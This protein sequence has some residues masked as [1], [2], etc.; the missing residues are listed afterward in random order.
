M[1]MKNS[2]SGRMHVYDLALTLFQV[3]PGNH[4]QKP[5][6]DSLDL[7]NVPNLNKL[8]CQ[9]I[10]YFHSSKNLPLSDSFQVQNE[11]YLDQTSKNE[12]EK[13]DLIISSWQSIIPESDD[14]KIPSWAGLQALLS[15]TFVIRMHLG[16]L[17]FL[18]STVTVFYCFQNYEKF[19]R[20]VGQLKQDALPLFCN[21]SVFR[22]AVGI[23]FQK[24]DQFRNVIPMLGCFYSAK[25]LQH[26]I[27]N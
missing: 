3:Q 21:E 27:G 5:Q 6:K 9:E 17:P 11:L 19:T 1:L 2:L 8:F 4:T 14:N 10:H 16:F 13:C 24:Q 7:T 23:F 18:A 12:L 22:I 25:C 15:N 20:L 26:R